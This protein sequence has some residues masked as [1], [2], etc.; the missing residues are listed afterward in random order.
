MNVSDP[1]P[2]RLSLDSSDFESNAM[3]L[4]TSDEGTPQVSYCNTRS[5]S[6]IPLLKF[7]QWRPRFINPIKKFPMARITPGWRRFLIIFGALCCMGLIA[8]MQAIILKSSVNRRGHCQVSL[9]LFIHVIFCQF[10]DWWL[11][12]RGLQMA[13]LFSSFCKLFLL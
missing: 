7:H 2:R 13:G 4:T 1:H 10:F 3:N 8:G 6:L 9:Y 12:L 5:N 11:R